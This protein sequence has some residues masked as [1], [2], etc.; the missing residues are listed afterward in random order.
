MQEFL[1]I[2]IGGTNIKGAIVQCDKHIITKQK[3]VIELQTQS[4]LKDKNI[5]YVIEVLSNE[6]IKY[7]K[8]NCN[9]NNILIALPGIVDCK[10]GTIIYSGTLNVHNVKLGE[11]ISK[12]IKYAFPKKA[13]NIYYFHDVTSSWWGEFHLTLLDEKHRKNLLY[14]TSSTG[15]AL[16]HN[17]KNIE[18]GWKLILQINSLGKIINTR[19]IEK[20]DL[21]SLTSKNLEINEYIF[22][23]LASGTSLKQIY[24][25][26][27]K[28][29]NKSYNQKSLL[30]FGKWLNE[31]A[32]K[33]DNLAIE[34]LTIAGYYAGY[35]LSYFLNHLSKTEKLLKVPFNELVIGGGL[36]E[37]SI[38][39]QA[40]REEFFLNIKEKNFLLIQSKSKHSSENVFLG[41][42]NSHY[43]NSTYQR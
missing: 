13:R 4:V 42:V 10:T 35:G 39:F 16:V 38:F 37:N 1:I 29:L 43:K 34:T 3:T 23:D 11:K 14:F 31:A 33:G 27:L 19:I 6:I 18:I 22:Q 41:M 9:I 21:K 36:G 30:D 17:G 32:L 28:R 5:N 26:K 15:V 25:K 8:I 40:L 2:D 24:L 20:N 7:L 12:K